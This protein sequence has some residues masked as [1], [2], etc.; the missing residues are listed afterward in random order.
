MKITAVI[1]NRN[2]GQFL[3]QSI[4]GVLSQSHED[5]ELII[6]DDMSSD[7]SYEII[8]SYAS[9]D[10]RIKSKILKINHGVNWCMNYALAISQ[11]DLFCGIAADDYLCDKDF[12]KNAIKDLIGGSLSGVY[13]MAERIDG[14]TGES[15]SILGSGCNE[16]AIS[17]S[18]FLAG[19]FENKCFVTGF[20][21]IWKTR[22]LGKIGGY[23]QRL[24][25]QA[26]YYVNHALPSA[27]GVYFYPIVTTKVRIFGKNGNYSSGASIEEKIHRHALFLAK[28]YMKFPHLSH[29]FTE[30]D[31]VFKW[32]TK[33]VYDLSDGND[34]DNWMKA[35]SEELSMNGI[36]LEQNIC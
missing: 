29:T 21:A 6:L 17:A 36:I 13:G 19:F 12:F 24:G 9:K 15:L 8:D 25:P 27:F 22:L 34:C 5:I 23:D 35:F 20:S 30:S 11:G 2:H 10:E 14:N 4:E 18:E 31:P 7:N 32:I 28:M 26:D 33:L 16:G 1:P 3:A